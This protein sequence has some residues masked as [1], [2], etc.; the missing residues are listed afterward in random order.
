MSIKGMSRNVHLKCYRSSRLGE[1]QQSPPSVW[2]RAVVDTL[3]W[4][5]HSGRCCS[6]G[7][8]PPWFGTCAIEVFVVSDCPRSNFR[9]P[10]L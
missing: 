5:R 1:E 8:E 4:D 6:F 7:A 3:V 2:T 9:H 10:T